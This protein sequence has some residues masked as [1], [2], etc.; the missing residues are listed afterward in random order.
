[1]WKKGAHCLG[2]DRGDDE[3]KESK[4]AESQM[5]VKATSKAKTVSYD[6]Y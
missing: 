5:L 2:E 1:M 4:L 3:K 6:V